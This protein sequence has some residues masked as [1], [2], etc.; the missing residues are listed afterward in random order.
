MIGNS[1]LTFFDVTNKPT[2]FCKAGDKIK[3]YEVELEEY[4]HILSNIKNYYIKPTIY[5][6]N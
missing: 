3:F 4:H 1:P 5:E 6:G 2:C